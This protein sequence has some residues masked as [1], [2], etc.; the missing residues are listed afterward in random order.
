MQT[1]TNVKPRSYISPYLTK[2]MKNM[3]RGKK[4]NNNNG[5]IFRPVLNQNP[6]STFK[7]I[8]ME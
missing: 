6:S 4:V 8:L 2:T 3:S 7:T 1:F 5:E